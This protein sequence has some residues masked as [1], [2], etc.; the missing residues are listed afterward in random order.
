MKNTHRKSLRP[1]EPRL[2]D[3]VQGGDRAPDSYYDWLMR[4]GRP[5]KP[6]PQLA[7]VDR[8]DR[9]AT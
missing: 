9:R 5:L 2:L 4:Q 1:L 8:K 6:I 7:M 3:H